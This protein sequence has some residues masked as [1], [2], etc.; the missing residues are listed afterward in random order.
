MLKSPQELPD[1]H[2]A[3]P[4]PDTTNSTSL[5]PTPP[6]VAP[7]LVSAWIFQYL[8]RARK[9]FS[10]KALVASPVKVLTGFQEL[11]PLVT[12]EM[13]S[14]VRAPA[15]PERANTSQL[16]MAWLTTPRLVALIVTTL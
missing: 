14:Y 2:V 8:P 3:L 13:P 10:V 4:V 16:R 9:P 5:S 1:V 15:A 11:V 6:P 7:L 12:P